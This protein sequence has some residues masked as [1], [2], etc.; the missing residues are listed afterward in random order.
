MRQPDLFAPTE[1]PAGAKPTLAAQAVGRG[2]RAQTFPV[3]RQ[4]LPI[5]AW[6]P[7]DRET[8]ERAC[9]RP[10]AFDPPG[11]AAHLR[12]ST[13]E[14]Y[15]RAYGRFLCW[16]DNKSLLLDN[17]A[18][19]ERLTKQRLLDFL[20]DVRVMMSPASLNQLLRSL[21]QAIAIL[22]PNH[23]WCWVTRNAAYS[24]RAELRQ[25]H[26]RR[27][28]FDPVLLFRR[29][30]DKMEIL[31]HCS[32]SM[33]IS[34]SYRDTLMAAL[35]CLFGLRR[36][37][38]AD[39]RY[40]KHLIVEGG[41]VRLRLDCHETKT[42][43]GIDTLV[44]VCLRRYILSYLRR[45]RPYLLSGQASDAV[46]INSH[47]GPLGYGA[48]TD[49]LKRVGLQL[50]GI[51]IDCHGFRHAIATA[52]I[53]RDPRQLDVASALLTHRSTHSVNQFYDLTDRDGACR[54]W[55]RLLERVLY[56]DTAQ[57]TASGGSAQEPSNETKSLNQY[58]FDFDHFSET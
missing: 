54:I 23:D 42:G 16:L 12:K 25:R 33:V 32:Q 24:T 44:P 14:N 47:D 53:V 49:C 21:R 3:G 9:A 19:A 2:R 43:A 31:D 46:W 1:S 55:N 57:P 8:F 52:L 50:L 56:G 26:H 58:N 45:H 34:V 10:G 38:L 20:L 30:V 40:G 11:V 18:P 7:V 35:Q 6:P 13:I 41:V 36:R 27:Q 48:I 4:C 5:F 22:A 39:L 51:P 28:P 29:C 15:A 37:N 17:E